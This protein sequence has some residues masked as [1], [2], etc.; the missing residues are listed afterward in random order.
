M[1][2]LALIWIGSFGMAVAA[3][4]VDVDEHCDEKDHGWDDD[5]DRP[6]ETH[7]HK[8]TTT[9]TT[10]SGGGSSGSGGTESSGS[11]GG[12]SAGS[13]GKTS[14]PSSGT[15]GGS[16]GG[17]GGTGAQGG[18]GGSAGAGGEGTG[19]TDGE[20]CSSCGDPEPEACLWGTST[21]EACC[22]L[23]V[24][25]EVAEEECDS[26]GLKLAELRLEKSCTDGH[27]QVSYQC[28]LE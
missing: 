18:V 1:K 25:A 24:L 6:C 20:P 8:D 5:D 14:G 11:S 23:E 4:H 10:G 27:R 28:C 16:V 7:V 2:A 26:Y 3:C 15:D 9:T 19:G 17:S 21:M 13:G 12:S 22:S